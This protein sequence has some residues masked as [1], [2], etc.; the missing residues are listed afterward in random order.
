MNFL[1]N[2]DEFCLNALD[3]HP[4]G[5]MQF[6]NSSRFL[7]GDGKFNSLLESY[8]PAKKYKKTFITSN[9]KAIANTVKPMKK[10]F[11]FPERDG[12]CPECGQKLTSKTGK[13]GT[14]YGCS[15]FPKCKY[16]CTVKQFEVA[17]NNWK[18]KQEIFAKYETGDDD[19]DEVEETPIQVAEPETQLSEKTHTI[20]DIKLKCEDCVF[21][22]LKD[23]QASC[24]VNGINFT[25][26]FEK[27]DT[28]MPAN[29]KDRMR[30]L[31]FLKALILLKNEKIDFLNE[32]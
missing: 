11:K 4:D 15:G 32:N 28:Y 1:N 30:M 24:R 9:N 6:V 20:S 14:F 23:D 26:P 27:C 25:I 22:E 18:K 13:Y 17:V 3:Q 8:S 21:Y 5:L 12:Y 7:P 31:E 2:L 16:K 19:D 10:D 29:K